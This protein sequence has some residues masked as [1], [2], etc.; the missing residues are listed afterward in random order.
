MI[1]TGIEKRP[2]WPPKAELCYWGT[3]GIIGG[4][5]PPL[6]PFGGEIYL[7]SCSPWAKEQRSLYGQFFPTKSV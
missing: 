5:T 7:T 6:K 1:S 3:G 4:E 2:N